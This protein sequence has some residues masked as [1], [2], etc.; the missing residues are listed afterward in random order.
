M[1]L[2]NENLANVAAN[3][4][5]ITPSYDRENTEIGIVHL[6]PGAFHRA[7]QAVYTE[8][9]M[10]LVGG[11]WGICGVSLRSATARDVLAKQD[12]LYT[13]AILDKEINY[14]IIG[15]VKEV[16]VA[17][18]QSQQVLDRLSAP[19]TKLVTLTI[20]EKGYCLGSDGRL[21]LEHSDIAHDLSN[22]SQP[23]SAIGYIVQALGQRKANNVAAFNVL[24]C[25]NVSGNGD[26][27]GRAV[28]DYAAQ[29]DADL[30]TWV[31]DNVAFPNAMVDSITPK[32]EDY[33]VDSVSKAIGA[34]DEWPI[35]REQFTQWVI[36]DNWNGERPAWDKV[37]VV[38]TSDV[39]G[40]E[41]AKLRLLNCLHSTLAY[42]GSLANFET[43][44]D[45]TS[46]SAFYEFICQ[47]ADD[48]VIGS[49][50][51]PKELDVVSYSK[52]IIQ[53]FLNPEIRHL[54]AQI[55]WDGSQKVQM[56]IL[57]IIEDN[58]ALGRSTKLLSL[59]LACWFEFICRA[60]KDDKEIV[61]PLASEFA[62]MP[63]LV[64]S[65][66]NEVVEA[67]LS[68]ESIFGQELKNNS[69]LKTQLANSLSALRLGDISQINS[70]V[71]KLC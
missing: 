50:V 41:K 26:K 62:S 57:P 17:S 8:N 38:F 10:N 6:G 9:A 70:V 24:S 21:D 68:I 25:D 46:D 59:S 22:T 15:A 29:V 23:I 14:Q 63:A 1:N 5:I 31:E 54:L 37:G 27:L 34:R 45:V 12:N 69:A 65:D 44:F 58:L 19:A 42:A 51:P 33:T 49:F 3:S 2:S 39:D 11:N 7:H 52:E 36:E 56:R 18:E 28:I 71:E 67:F 40:F 61:D 35:Q 55:A 60:L 13:L 4:A 47:L 53:R 66:T 30:A 43:V 64:S 16:L 32:T 20:T 48:E